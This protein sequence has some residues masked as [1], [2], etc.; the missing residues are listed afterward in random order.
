M[1]N[2]PSELFVL[3]CS[4]MHRELRI[5]AMNELLNLCN[6]QP[7]EAGK[8]IIRLSNDLETI[9]DNPKILEI[10]KVAAERLLEKIRID[11]DHGKISTFVSLHHDPLM[12][13]E[14]LIDLI[15]LSPRAAEIA[16]RNALDS[17]L[18]EEHIR[19][20][21]EL[22]S[23]NLF[24]NEIKAA[25]IQ[26]LDKIARMIN[27]IRIRESEVISIFSGRDGIFFDETPNLGIRDNTIPFD[28]KRNEKTAPFHLTRKKPAKEMNGYEIR[29][30]DS[31]IIEIPNRV[32]VASFSGFK[33][34][35]LGPW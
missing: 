26:T 3:A 24:S 16:I 18:E 8:Y 4:S 11:A 5:N 32:N 25:A 12:T 33:R 31:G 15:N 35:L 9:V 6:T 21:I 20:L 10:K 30:M 2:T 14:F 17:P 19:E 13:S 28:L 23:S 7:I 22:R 1:V 27:A 34:I 29:R